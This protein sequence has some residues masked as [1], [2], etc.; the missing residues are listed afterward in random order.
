M[1]MVVIEADVK[2]KRKRVTEHSF[3]VLTFSWC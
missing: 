3:E 1:I 2:K